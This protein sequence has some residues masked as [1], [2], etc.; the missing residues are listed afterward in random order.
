MLLGAESRE[1]I[2][3][4]IAIR[5]SLRSVLLVELSRPIKV[6]TETVASING[7]N[8]PALQIIVSCVLY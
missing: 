8:T 7:R 4:P 6:K 1:V 3:S 2:I 5:I